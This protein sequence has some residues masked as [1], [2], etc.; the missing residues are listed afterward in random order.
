[1]PS[2]VVFLYRSFPDK[3]NELSKINEAGVYALE[4]TIIVGI[5]Q[6][7][8]NLGKRQ[9]LVENY[10]LREFE[11]DQY[12]FLHI[13]KTM[14]SFNARLTNVEI[15]RSFIHP[16]LEEELNEAIIVQNIEKIYSIIE[17]YS[18]LGHDVQSLEYYFNNERIRFTRLAELDVSS[19]NP[20]I[21][22]ILN[23]TPIGF[24]SGVV[25]EDELS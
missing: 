12:K 1:M 20:D 15:V 25:R 6:N 21:Y 2:K 19:S 7:Q 5:D 22:S 9:Q 18:D 16:H 17:E 13:V 14:P 24:L 10:L 8:V 3:I 11:V 23:T 4:G